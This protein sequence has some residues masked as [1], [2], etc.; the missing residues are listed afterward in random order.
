MRLLSLAW[1][2]LKLMD[3]GL[4][5]VN[6]RTGIETKPKEITPVDIDRDGIESLRVTHPAKSYNLALPEDKAIPM[7]L[8]HYRTKRDPERTPEPFGGQPRGAASHSGGVF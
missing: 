6:R 8:E 4:V 3:L 5:A 7:P 2:R 1:S